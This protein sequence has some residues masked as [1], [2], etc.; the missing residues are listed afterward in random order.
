MP[1]D[2]LKAYWPDGS[3]EEMNAELNKKEHDMEKSYFLRGFI[4]QNL[5]RKT[6]VVAHFVDGNHQAT[7]LNCA[8]IGSGDDVE[9]KKEYY[10]NFPHDEKKVET[11]ILVPIKLTNA[12][13]DKMSKLS[14]SSQRSVE[15]ITENGKKEFIT[16]MIDSLHN[17]LKQF[18]AEYYLFGI[19]EEEGNNE[20][21]IHKHIQV[22]AAEI[23]QLFKTV[24]KEV[25]MKQDTDY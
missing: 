11:T 10:E 9:A 5:A 18:R 19:G 3:L 24:M 17:Q 22:V 6:K 12:F 1:S 2:G 4:H 14:F 16:N 25:M 20:E 23:E 15:K 13:H 21:E 8:L 7:A